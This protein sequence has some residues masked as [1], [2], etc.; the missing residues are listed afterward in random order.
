LHRPDVSRQSRGK[1]QAG[2]KYHTNAASVRIDLYIV[3]SSCGW[4]RATPVCVGLG[5]PT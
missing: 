3:R 2:G 1:R 4:Q 5:S